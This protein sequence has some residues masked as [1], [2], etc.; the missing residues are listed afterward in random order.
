MTDKKNVKIT[1]ADTMLQAKIGMGPLDAKAVARCQEVIDTNNFDFAPLAKDYLN[2]LSEA[3]TEVRSNT[4]E[5]EAA[6]HKLAEPV[7]QLKAHAA[8]FRYAL[9]GNLANIML[10]FLEA[11]QS[12]DQDVL[13]IVEAHHQTLTAIVAKKMEGDGGHFGKQLEEEL[14]GA[15]KRY[16]SKKT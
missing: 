2:E 7:M 14:K 12:L 1:K 4:M 16:F 15:C 9:I 10:S 8:M 11:V 3:I 5:M 6:L 13:Q